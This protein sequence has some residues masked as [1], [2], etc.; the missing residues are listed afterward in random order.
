MH[1]LCGI[2]GS[3][4]SLLSITLYLPADS[5]AWTQTLC[6]ALM[7]LKVLHTL[8]KDLVPTKET[9]RGEGRHDGMD[10]G[11]RRKK[12]MSMWAVSQVSLPSRSICR[13][14]LIGT[15]CLSS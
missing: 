3:C 12:K 15:S 4:R 5:S 6:A 1:S 8:N 2:I 7:D 9:A 10:I 11:W 14:M 13:S